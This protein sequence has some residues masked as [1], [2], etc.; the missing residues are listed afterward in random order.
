[1]IQALHFMLIRDRDSL[2]IEVCPEN[3]TLSNIGRDGWHAIHSM[4]PDAAQK[5]TKPQDAII[6][7]PDNHRTFTFS[8][9]TGRLAITGTE[10]TRAFE[11]HLSIDECWV[12]QESLRVLLD[13]TKGVQCF[14]M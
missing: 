10:R 7:D 4:K 1:M 12:F 14:E 9:R 3:V 5:L 11:T 6:E 2:M 13:M 8:P